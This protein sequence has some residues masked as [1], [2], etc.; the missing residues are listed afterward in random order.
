MTEQVFQLADGLA[1]VSVSANLT[2]DSCTDFKLQL[3]RLLW[4]ARRRPSQAR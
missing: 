4:E 3:E 2:E 1:M